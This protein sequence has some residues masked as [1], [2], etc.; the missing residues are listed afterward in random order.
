MLFGLP[1]LGAVSQRNWSQ[2]LRPPMPAV[3]DIMVL[4]CRNITTPWFR[5]AWLIYLFIFRLS[6]AFFSQHIAGHCHM[7]EIFLSTAWNTKLVHKY[8]LI[9]LKNISIRLTQSV[10][11]AG[12]CLPTSQ[13]YWYNISIQLWSNKS[14]T[15]TLSCWLIKCQIGNATEYV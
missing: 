3:W 6:N 7:R 15:G 8:T 1:L 4:R 10:Y 13:V 14:F 2:I 11:Y 12:R 9:M 5:L